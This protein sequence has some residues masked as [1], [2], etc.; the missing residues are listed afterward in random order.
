M[1]IKTISLGKMFNLG[2]YENIKPEITAD[3]AEGDDVQ[4]CFDNLAEELK[5]FASKHAR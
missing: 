3:L 1:K 2:N 5:N 4:T